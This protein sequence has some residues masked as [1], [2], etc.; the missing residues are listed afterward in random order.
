MTKV[1]IIV[2]SNNVLYATNGLDCCLT[3]L[4]ISGILAL[5][6]VCGVMSFLSWRGRVMVSSFESFCFPLQTIPTP[7]ASIYTTPVCPD[8]L[9]YLCMTVPKLRSRS[10]GDSLH[11]LMHP[12][13]LETILSSCCCPSAAAQTRAKSAFVRWTSFGNISAGQLRPGI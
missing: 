6:Y 4:H 13:H 3:S 9:W 7:S 1:S 11:D 12:D 5:G 8:V 10:S 2:P